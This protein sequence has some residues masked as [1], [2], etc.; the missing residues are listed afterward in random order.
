VILDCLLFGTIAFVKGIN[1]SLSSHN[2][3][4]E[5]RKKSTHT[6]TEGRQNTHTHTPTRRNKIMTSKVSSN[7]SSNMEEGQVIESP[8]VDTTEATKYQS[9]KTLSETQIRSKKNV[10]YFVL[11]VLG[12]LALFAVIF[13]PIYV[14]NNNNDDNDDNDAN[15]NVESTTT[16]STGKLGRFVFLRILDHLYFKHSSL[17]HSSQSLLCS[18]ENLK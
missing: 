13:A 3:G 8:T 7:E 16:A 14:N 2:I 12:A 15:N 6:H 10:T 4:G 17:L 9:T 18:I 11:A 1:K 5:K